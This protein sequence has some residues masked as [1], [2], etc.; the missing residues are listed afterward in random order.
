MVIRH[1]WELNAKSLWKL[2]ARYKCCSFCVRRWPC[3]HSGGVGTGVAE[4]SRRQT[5]SW[6]GI[7]VSGSAAHCL[8]TD[9]CS[10]CLGNRWHGLFQRMGRCRGR[11]GQEGGDKIQPSLHVLSS[12]IL[13]E[14]ARR[15]EYLQPKFPS[16]LIHT[17]TIL[18]STESWSLE[19]SL[20]MSK[21]LF[22]SFL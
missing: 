15:S 14:T 22:L 11:G 16:G 20:Q 5:G 18:F 8:S 7:W 9:F 1:K 21:G 3:T 2:S 10:L 13:R 4:Q 6:L 17:Q 12:Y 19:K